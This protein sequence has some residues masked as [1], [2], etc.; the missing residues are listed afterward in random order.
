[1]DEQSNIINNNIKLP[2]I[3][4]ESTRP[5]TNKNDNLTNNLNTLLNQKNI[6]PLPIYEQI[7]TETKSNNKGTKLIMKDNTENNKIKRV[8]SSKI[9]QNN[10]EQV[11]FLPK[12]IDRFGNP[13]YQKGKQKVTFIDRIS[14][15]NL[16][17]VI[18]VESFKEYNKLE[19]LGNKESNGCCVIL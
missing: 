16:C 1:M 2:K 10:T 7:K 17:E 13:I 3:V 8:K 18:K 9:N 5:V 19:D 6:I 14:K 11:Q 15:T 12:R 4:S